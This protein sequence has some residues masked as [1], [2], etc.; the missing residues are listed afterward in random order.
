MEQRGHNAAVKDA[1]ITPNV[2]ECALD[3]GQKLNCAAL[4]DAQSSLRREECA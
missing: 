1:Q 3:M 4:T 2:G